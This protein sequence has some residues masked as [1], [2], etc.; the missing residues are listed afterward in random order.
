M[1]HLDPLAYTYEA[2]YHCW[3]CATSRF[4]VDEN[5]FVPWN[6]EDSEGNPVGIVA[7]WDEW[8][9]D[10]DYEECEVLVCGDCE[11]WIEESHT[12]ACIDNAEVVCNLERV[13]EFN[14]DS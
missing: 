12:W 13:R 14:E 11:K 7:P 3:D 2:D 6:A 4:G 8:R 9:S 10:P 1:G 5:G